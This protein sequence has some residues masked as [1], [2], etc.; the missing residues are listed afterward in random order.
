MDPNTSLNAGRTILMDAVILN[1]KEA[2]KLLL[3]KGADVNAK[4]LNGE[5]A[6]YFA[7]Q[8]SNQ[9]MVDLLRPFIISASGEAKKV[10]AEYTNQ[11]EYLRRMN[12]LET[13][14]SNNVD[15]RTMSLIVSYTFDPGASPSMME[16]NDLLESFI[17]KVLLDMNAGINTGLGILLSPE[18]ERF[19]SAMETSVNFKGEMISVYN[20]MVN[21][22]RDYRT[23][24]D[25][26]NGAEHNVAS[27]ILVKQQKS[28]NIV[29]SLRVFRGGK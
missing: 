11:A 7:V 5:S 29:K 18:G 22:I 16:A 8:T 9:V 1:N 17:D 14:R 4:T 28:R 2:V 19:L 3:A 20:N 15:E 27:F 26:Y 12:E 6:I 23:Y 10:N 25:M 21:S 24:I 13:R